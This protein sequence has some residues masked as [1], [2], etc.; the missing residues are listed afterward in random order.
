MLTRISACMHAL[1]SC[2]LMGAPDER[3]L[4]A[5][6][7]CLGGWFFVKEKSGQLYIS[8]MLRGP[9][10]K[11]SRRPPWGERRLDGE[12]G[13]ARVDWDCT[14]HRNGVHRELLLPDG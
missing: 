6:P 10:H 13:L 9:P 5:R 12:R 11:A 2:G 4:R 1:S 7:R 8:S 14:L 3:G